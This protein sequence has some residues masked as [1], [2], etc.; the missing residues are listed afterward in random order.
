M[1][2]D[3]GRDDGVMRAEM[4][5]QGRGQL[6]DL[7][8]QLPLGQPGQCR[9]VALPGDQRLDHRPPG[10]GQ[11]L[12][13]DGGQLDPGVLEHLL[14]PGDLRCPRVDLGLAVARQLPQLPDRRR[15][16]EAGP[17]HAVRGDVSKPLSIGHIGLATGDVLD[18]MRVAQ[19]HQEPVLQ[20]VV[21]RLPVHPGR[22]HRGQRDRVPGQPFR[23]GGQPAG[24]RAEPAL[25]GSRAPARSR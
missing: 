24:G 21:D 15:R 19:P 8:P 20:R 14:H 4:A 25:L 6:R 3:A 1:G 10:L 2:Q 23:Q 22:L 12:R 18:V 5:V 13:G 9:G 11:H 16:H 7:R 17:D